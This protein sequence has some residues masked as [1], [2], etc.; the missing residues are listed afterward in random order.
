MPRSTRIVATGFLWTILI[1]LASGPLVGQEHVPG[2]ENETDEPAHEFHPNHFGGFLGVSA[3]SDVDE[4][5]LTMGLEYA[6]RFSKRWAVAIY[7]E[8][9]SSQL[10]RDFVVAVG[11]VFY[12]TSG[13]GL[14]LAVGGELVDKPVE[15]NDEIVEETELDFMLRVGAAYGFAITPTAGIG[16][17]LF[18]DQVGDR[19]TV[20]FGLGLV[21]GF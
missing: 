17:T 15:H 2:S 13:L 9:V 20:V 10:E 8:L 11:G 21:V 18:V 12:P 16:P 5:A 3:R 19:T 7:T 1:L 4:V 6:R 14:V